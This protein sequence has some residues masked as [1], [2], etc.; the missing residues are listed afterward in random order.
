[1]TFHP[2]AQGARSAS[3]SVADDASGSPQSVALSGTGSTSSIA[4]DR[5]LGTKTENVG[6]TTMTLTT[7]GAAAAG[8]RVFVEWNN[9]TR[10]LTSLAGGGLTWTVDFQAKESNNNHL[11][12]A[13]ANAPAGLPSGTVLTAT[14]S[15]SVTHGLI[16]AA[17]FTGIAGTSAVDGTGSTTGAG[18]RAWSASVTTTNATD[19]VLAFS[20]IDANTTSTATAPATEIHDFGDVNFYGWATTAYSTAAAAGAQ[21]IAGTWAAN[22][23]AIGNL[24]IAVAYKAG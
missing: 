4:F 10:T 11:A 9:S 16:A 15:G 14:F 17:S 13:S 5:S 19:L 23:G 12:I 8:S 20:T 21:T 7:A 3:L 22:T 1:V 6:G 18:V 24:T 2:G